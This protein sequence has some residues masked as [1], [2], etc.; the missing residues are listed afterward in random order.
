MALENRSIT[1]QIIYLCLVFAGVIG[2]TLLFTVWG[3]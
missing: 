3:L 2:V 1:R